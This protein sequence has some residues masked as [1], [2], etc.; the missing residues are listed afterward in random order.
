MKITE[1]FTLEELTKSATAKRL[2]INNS[3]TP[4][5]LKKLESLCVLILE[6][7]R[8]KYGKPIVVTSGYRSV[9]L[10][11][12]VGGVNTSQHIYGEA[13]DIRSLS[14]SKEDNKELFILIHKMISAGE[15][16]VGQLINENDYDWI[17]ISL[18]TKKHLNEVL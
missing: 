4:E 17:H 14:D 18:P 16:V 12:R 8:E 3:P 2:G 1:H 11:I 5:A 7:I 15:I 13:A 10:N 9:N 6:P